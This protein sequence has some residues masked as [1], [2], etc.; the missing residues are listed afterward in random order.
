MTGKQKA[1]FSRGRRWGIGFQVGFIIFVVFSIVLMVNYLSGAY[2]HRFHWSSARQIELSSRT[3][4]YLQSLT[5]Q[6]KVTIYYDRDEPFFTM[7]QGLLKEYRNVNP[8]ISI[9]TVDYLRDAVAAQRIKSQYKQLVF[10]SSTNIVIIESGGRA[11]PLDGNAL[12]LYAEEQIPDSKELAFQRRAVAFQGE[13][14]FTSALLAVCSGQPFKACFL[15]G[16][17]E[18]V[19]TSSDTNNGYTTF[20]AIARQNYIEP[21]EL[22]SLLGSNA[23]PTGALLVIAGPNRRLEDVE[24]AKI[25]RFLTE[26]GRLLVLFN[27]DSAGRETGLEGLLKKWGVEVKHSIIRD[28]EHS[29][30]PEKASDLTTTSLTPHP[31]VNA[32]YARNWSLMFYEPR[33]IARSPRKD[34][35]AEGL[36]V[37]EIVYTSPDGFVDGQESRHGQFPLMVAIEKGDTK[38]IVAGSTRILVAGDSTFLG[39]QL[40]EM[41]ANRDFAGF[42]LNWLV[43]RPQLLEGVAARPIEQRRL[44]LTAAD[45]AKAEWVLLGGMPGA[46]LLLGGVVW[47]RRRK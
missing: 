41:A 32:L 37:D 44:L 9:E 14:M 21:V 16:H 24:L 26:G 30:D 22:F 34:S 23:I 2:F 4:H 11:L 3:V 42:A 33:W 47:L 13:K 17:G 10:P 39:N 31:A 45:R 5:N 15:E 19:I 43:D 1:T 7:V 12:T 6:V 46:A 40:I 8:R 20:A 18:N 36:K 25:D 38:G 35:A 28:R 27:H 29:M